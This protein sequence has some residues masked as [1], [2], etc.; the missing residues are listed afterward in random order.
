MHHL[1]R[2]FLTSP[3]YLLLGRG[4]IYYLR[5]DQFSNLNVYFIAENKAVG[6]MKPGHV[7]TI[8][9]MICEGEQFG[10]SQKSLH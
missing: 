3:C 5:C 7:F 4:F 6:V 1:S 8:E 10:K 9:P 2:T